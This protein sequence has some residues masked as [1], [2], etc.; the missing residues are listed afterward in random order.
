MTPAMD[1]SVVSINLL[2][3]QVT[4]HYQVTRKGFGVDHIR[5]N[6]QDIDFKRED[7]PY[8]K[9][10]AIIPME[11]LQPLLS[12]GNGKIDISL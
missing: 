2:G 11:V 5:I 10:G 6:D 8:R 1:G 12:G 4:I 7:N 3:S 9:G